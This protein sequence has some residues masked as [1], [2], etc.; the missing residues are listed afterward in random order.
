MAFSSRSLSLT[1]VS[2]PAFVTHAVCYLIVLLC[3]ACPST[4]QQPCLLIALLMSV[5]DRVPD[6]KNKREDG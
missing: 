5:C 6:G 4:P 1:G 3:F 2:V